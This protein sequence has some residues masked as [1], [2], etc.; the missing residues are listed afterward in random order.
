MECIPDSAAAYHQCS[1][2][3]RTVPSLSLTSATLYLFYW[4]EGNQ[5]VDFVV[6]VG[7]TLTAIEVTSGRSSDTQ[8]G[9]TAF[10]EAFKPA[11]KLLVGGD[12]IPVEDFLLAP[13][14]RL[15]AR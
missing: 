4:R 2:A 7:R 1:S 12:G 3:V 8:L 9:L 14:A 6:R 15:V 11:R 5:E 10:E 13:V